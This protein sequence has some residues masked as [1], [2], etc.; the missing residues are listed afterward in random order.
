MRDEL[1]LLQKQGIIEPVQFSDWA[2][3]IVPVLKSDGSV[4][5]C[6]DLPSI[7]WQSKTFT[8]LDFSHAYQQMELDE[9]SRQ[10]V[11]IN[12]HRGTFAVQSIAFCGFV[13]TLDIPTLN[14]KSVTRH[15]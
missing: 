3:P 6:G 13:S 7:E 1:E 10:Y 5:V 11:P 2:A 4:R 15:H 12:T 9:E 8:K 14:G